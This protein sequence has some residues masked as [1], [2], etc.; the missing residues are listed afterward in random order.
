MTAGRYRFTGSVR[1]EEKAFYEEY[2]FLVYE[3]FVPESEVAR[4][5]AEATAYQ[6]AIKAG[7]V[8]AEHIDNVAPKTRD[9]NGEITIHHRL[10]YFTQ[11]SETAAGYAAS[12]HM[13]AIRTGLGGEDYWLLED[14][15]NGAVWQLK[16]GETKSGYSRIRWHGDFPPGHPLSPAFTAGLYLDDSNRFNGCLA[17]IPGSHRHAMG[18]V[19]PEPF[20][21]EAKA[22]DLICHHEWIYHGSEA[23]PRPTDRRATLYFY[24]CSGT[25]PGNGQGYAKKEDLPAVRSLFVSA[26]PE[27][28]K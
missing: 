14:T 22:G 10:N 27:E 17:V 26:S 3:N 11:H 15:M 13:Q 8:P 4:L 9:G 7:K 19:Q 16:S 18:T 24:Y 2:G 6:E 5:T 23:M 1:P 12:A 28:S 21:V 20:Y 25:H